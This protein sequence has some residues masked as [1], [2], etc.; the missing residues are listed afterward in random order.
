LLAL[1]ETISPIPTPP[2][3]REFKKAEVV[4]EIASLRILSSS[5][6]LA[7]GVAINS[8]DPIPPPFLWEIVE[9]YSIAA[10]CGRED[11]I[12]EYGPDLLGV[13]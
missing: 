3:F 7:T 1:N 2:P 11:G 4:A 6:L 10:E 13:G 5:L 8:V 12:D 9:I